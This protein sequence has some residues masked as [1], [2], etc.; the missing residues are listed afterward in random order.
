[1]FVAALLWTAQTGCPWCD[2]TAEFGGWNTVFKRFRRWV[3]AD[4]FYYMFSALAEDVD[5]EDAMIDGTITKVHRHEQGTKGGLKASPVPHGPLGAVLESVSLA[6]LT[7]TE[8]SLIM[9]L[10]D[11]FRR[12]LEITELEARLAAFQAQPRSF[13]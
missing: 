9:G 5:F 13:G 2:L 4:A 3:K 11:P 10:V 12:T 1:M 6:K 8:L 7:L